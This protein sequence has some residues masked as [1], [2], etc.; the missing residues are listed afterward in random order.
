M[1]L[2]VPPTNKYVIGYVTTPDALATTTYASNVNPG[3]TTSAT[4]VL[5]TT[6]SVGVSFIGPRSGIVEIYWSAEHSHS[7]VN[8]WAIMSPN[9]RAGDIVGS[10][11]V[12][13]AANDNV[14]T[15]CRNAT[16]LSGDKTISNFYV[17]TGLTPGQTYNVEL[18]ARTA[19]AGT[20]TY[21]YQTVMVKPVA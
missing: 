11:A 12:F 5:P 10:G 19:S 17:L 2:D 20:A 1:V 6:A 21:E 16:A 13:Y 4:F 9:V 7:V 18:Y 15:R 14:V 3:T 8:G